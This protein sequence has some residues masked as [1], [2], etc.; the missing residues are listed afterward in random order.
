M[1]VAQ[2]QH[3]GHD[4]LGAKAV[5]LLYHAIMHTHHAYIP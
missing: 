2:R 1:N 4:A 5:V 3:N